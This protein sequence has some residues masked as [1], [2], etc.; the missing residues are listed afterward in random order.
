MKPP[1]PAGQW[2]HPRMGKSVWIRLYA[3]ISYETKTI[4][5]I[6][7]RNNALSIHIKVYLQSYFVLSLVLLFAIIYKSTFFTIRTSHSTTG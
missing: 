6:S 3:L 2:G 5:K 7:S 1:E 4:H